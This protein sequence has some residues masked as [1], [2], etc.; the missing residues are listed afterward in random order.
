VVGFALGHV[1]Y[2]PRRA[3]VT[4]LIG[5]RTTIAAVAAR[6]V[7]ILLIGGGIAGATAA[8]TLRA[9]GHE[10]SVLLVGRE[11]D[12][13]YHRP[14][15]TKEYLRGQAGRADGLVLPEAW[16]DE[17]GVELLTRTSVAAL[18]PA[19]RTATLSSREDV[20]FEQ[21]LV[22]TG[23]M[24]RRL[25][26]DG[27]QLE[28]IHYLRGPANADALRRDLDGAR[29]AVCV[30]GSYI[31]C[32][33]AASLTELGLG[34][35]V[36]LQEDDP[37]AHH[38][39]PA[40]GRRVRAVLEDHGIEVCG[41]ETDDRFEGDERV[42]T[43]H[44]TSGRR[45]D[46]DVVVCGVGALPD[47]MLARRSGL[48]IGPLGGV[49]CD[50]RL[51]VAGAPHLLAAGDMCEYDSVLHGGGARIEHEEVAA[52][53]GAAAARTML[54]ADRAHDEVPY[55][56][57]DLS[58]WLALEYAGLGRPGREEIVRGDPAGGPLAVWQ[59]DGGRVV[60]LLSI[61]GGG[62]LDAARRLI[63]AGD[64]VGAAGLPA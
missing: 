32:E 41:G 28:G 52:A 23:A 30:G 62:D 26:V 1:R 64:P 10:G 45:V 63:A 55:F 21:A 35:T 33:V 46:A 11:Q 59:L 5:R 31:G 17:Q 27:A 29:R 54:G 48:E 60:G 38:F 4:L 43:V 14:P 22:A 42:A 61:D 12:P 36:L 8:A 7:D 25:A 24:V 51:R 50:S 58:D 53:Q 13:P 49:L 40:A 37:L 16:W 34:V 15:V 20:A 19:A 2:L 56:F 18:D 9:E 44:T 6:Q 3:G 57:S 39:G 47:V